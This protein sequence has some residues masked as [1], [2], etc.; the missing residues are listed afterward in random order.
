MLRKDDQS[1]YK[2]AYLHLKK[3]MFT[4]AL[5][6]VVCV[7]SGITEVEMSGK[8]SCER[9]NGKEVYL[10]HEPMAQYHWYRYRYAT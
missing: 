2:K 4:P 3:R 6:M 5:R 1:V 7:P 9:V 8:E 10:I